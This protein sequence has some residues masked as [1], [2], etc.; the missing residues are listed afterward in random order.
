MCVCSVCGR[1]GFQVGVVVFIL[2]LLN[3][4]P[5]VYNSLNAQDKP[6]SLFMKGGHFLL[7]NLQDFEAFPSIFLT[8][9]AGQGGACGAHLVDF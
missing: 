6:Q 4:A 1:L 5:K 7:A 2:F 9:L 3:L 8:L